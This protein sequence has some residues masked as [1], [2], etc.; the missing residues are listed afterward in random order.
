[1]TFDDDHQAIMHLRSRGYT[2]TRQWNW[3]LPADITNPSDED[4]EAADYLFFEWDWGHF[5]R[6]GEPP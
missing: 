2:L 1:M 3:Q 4:W 5:L 6:P